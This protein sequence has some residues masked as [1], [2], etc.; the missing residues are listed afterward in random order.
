MNWNKLTPMLLATAF[1][2]ASCEK[3]DEDLKDNLTA[4]EGTD[5]NTEEF[6]DIEV[7][8]FVYKGMNDIY[9]YKADVPVLA[10][11]YF[12]STN[13]KNTYLAGFSSPEALF[14]DLLSSQDRFSFIT[15]DYVALEESFKGISSSIAGMEFGLGRITNTNNVFGYLQYVL[16]NTSA[17]E[18]GLTRGTVFTEVNGTKLTL[19][20]YADLMQGSFT[21]NVG[22]VENG[23]IVLTDETV[24]LDTAGYTE[25]PV[26]INK[27]L[28]VEGKKVGYLMYN[29]FIADF[30]DELNAAFG[31]FKA[32]GINDL[33]LDLRYNGGGSVESA[34]DLASMITGQFEGKVFMKEQWNEKYQTYFEEEDPESLLNR[35]NP[36]IRTQ[37]AIN[38]LQLSKVYII[39]TLGTASASELVINGLDPY[40]DVVQVGTTTTGKFQA[41]ATLY[42]SPDY[43]K[44]GANENHTYAIQPLIFKSANSVGKSDYVNGLSPDIEIAEDLNDLG[45]LGDPSEP[46]LQAALNHMLGKAQQTKSQA[47]KRAAENFEQIGQG[48]MHLP[49]FQRMYVDELPPVLDRE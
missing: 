35:F 7:E 13:E 44:E 29:S 1:L 37:E 18:A 24:T 8:Q 17:A 12:A 47:Q 2:F 40:I 9:L 42:D 11:D 34:V 19:D 38:S 45:T 3:D 27:I 49:T 4:T 46:L 28:D 20:N 41:S 30:D 5:K 15:D 21:I 43:G 33:V 39:T 22:Y 23:S 25:N 6:G 10:D 36:V 32:A 31:E 48:D 26:F 14:D 16:P